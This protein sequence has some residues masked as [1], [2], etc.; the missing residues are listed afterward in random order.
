M[1]SGGGVA[2]GEVVGL[3]KREKTCG[4]GGFGKKRWWQVEGYEEKVWTDEEVGVEGKVR[5]GGRVGK[6]YDGAGG[7]IRREGGRGG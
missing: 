7:W 1:R 2:R 3:Q 6:E 4:C 5:I